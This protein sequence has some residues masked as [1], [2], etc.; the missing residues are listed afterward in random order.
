MRMRLRGFMTRWGWALEVLCCCTGLMPSGH[1]LHPVG[2]DGGQGRSGFTAV[3]RPV[4][5]LPCA[6]RSA[7]RLRS[8][9]N[10]ADTR[11]S[12]NR[13]RR[14]ACGGLPPLHSGA[15]RRRGAAAALPPVLAAALLARDGSTARPLASV[16]MAYLHAGCKVVGGA[17]GA[18]LR[19]RAAQTCGGSPPQ[20]DRGLGDLWNG[21]YQRRCEALKPRP[22]GRA[23]QGTR[24]AAEGVA[25]KRQQPHPQPCVH[26]QK[27][28]N[29][30]PPANPAHKNAPATTR[31][32][33][34]HAAHRRCWGA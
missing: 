25:V 9:R 3:V 12:I 11:R 4:A 17:D 22:A 21:A 23:A 2:K 18:P 32:R 6:P 13:P 34:G 15:Q 29:P 28:L 7:G 33:G 1:K 19:R 10:G 31:S 24:S 26:K 20:A 27:R 14:S 8:L 5:G 30:P 16:T